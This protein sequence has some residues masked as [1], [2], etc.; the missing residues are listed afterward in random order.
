MEIFSTKKHKQ[1]EWEH[2]KVANHG[3]EYGLG[4]LKS[5]CYNQ[6]SKKL[7]HIFFILILST[8]T[9]RPTDQKNTCSIRNR[10]YRGKIKKNY[11]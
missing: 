1:K 10:I 7:S 2:P 6:V 9:Q 5:I 4:D 8:M 3:W 11:L